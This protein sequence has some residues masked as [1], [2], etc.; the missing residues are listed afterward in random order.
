MRKLYEI[1]KVLWIQKRIVVAATIWGNTVIHFCIIDDFIVFSGLGG[2]PCPCCPPRLGGLSDTLGVTSSIST[3]VSSVLTG[4]SPSLTGNGTSET[5]EKLVKSDR[6]VL[7]T[8][9]VA[10]LRRKAQEHS[11]A[12]WQ[13]LQ[14][15]QGSEALTNGPT[16]LPEITLPSEPVKNIEKMPKEDS[17]LL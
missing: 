3:P 12:I 7:F 11:A 2:L 13:S 14:Q 8:A 15:I 10:E 4:S 6:D 17:P 9:S 5:D 1:F 16:A